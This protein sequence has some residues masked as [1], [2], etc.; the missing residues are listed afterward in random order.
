MPINIEADANATITASITITTGTMY[1]KAGTAGSTLS[2]QGPIGG[3]ATT[4]VRI[5]GPGIVDMSPASNNT[6]PGSTVVASNDAVGSAGILQLSSTSSGQVVP[7][8]LQI[9]GTTLQ[10]PPIAH[11]SY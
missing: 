8:D 6:Y 1:I 9:G 10:S 7:G 4:A 11:S 2:L 5:Y 3:A